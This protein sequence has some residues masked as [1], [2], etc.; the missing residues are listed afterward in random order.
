MRN[1]LKELNIVG[2]VHLWEEGEAIKHVIDNLLKWCNYICLVMDFPDI[3][4]DVIIREYKKKYPEII[5]FEYFKY[6]IVRTAKNCRRRE[7]LIREQVVEQK[8]AM[9]KRIHEEIKPVDILLTPDS[10]EIYTNYLPEMLEKFWKS[11]FT[12]ICTK[13]IDVY[14]NFYLI[15]NKSMMS[16]WRAYKYQPEISFTPRRFQDHYYPYPA[17]EAWRGL[18]GGFIHLTSHKDFLNLK[19]RINHGDLLKVHPNAKFWKLDKPAYELT[20]EEYVDIIK[21]KKPDFIAE[22][23]YDKIKN[24]A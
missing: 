12:S 16:H 1:F 9:V 14:G 22:K 2:I 24:Y 20:P 23:D 4:T 3:I 5:Q 7:K 13:P 15:H 19:K 18:N 11:D 17:K 10:D 6:D 21:N 8:L